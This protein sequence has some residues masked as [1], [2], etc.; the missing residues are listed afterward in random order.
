MRWLRA[1]LFCLLTLTATIVWA[2]DEAEDNKGFIQNLIE[3]AL[4]GLGREVIITDFAGALSSSITM[5]EMTIADDTGVWLT[6]RGVVLDWKR[7]AL[8][9][10]RLDVT[11]LAAEEII[12]SRSPSADPEAPAA[13]ASVFALPELPVAVEID[14]IAAPRIVLGEALFGEE[15]TLALRGSAQ[16]ADGAGDVLL[17]INRVDRPEDAMALS[18]SFANEDRNLNISLNLVEAPSG[19]LSNVLNLPDAPSIE[20]RVAGDGP[21]DNFHADIGLF[22]NEESRLTG[23]VHFETPLPFEGVEELPPTAFDITFTGDVAPLFATDYQTFFGPEVLLSAKG[24]REKSG[25]LHLQS[26]DVDTQALKLD[27]HLTLSPE[28]WPEKFELTGRLAGLAGA[29]VLLPLTGERTQITEAKILL[30]YDSTAG[31]SWLAEVSLNSLDRSDITLASAKLDGTGTLEH[32]EGTAIGQILG[33]VE[34]ALQGLVLENEA[35][36]KAVGSDLVA[37]LTFAWEEDQVFR[38]PAFRA[39]GNSFDIAGSGTIDQLEGSL[40]RHVTLDADLQAPDLSLFADLVEQPLSGAAGLKIQGSGELLG[41]SFDVSL[42]GT[43]ENL[44]TGIEQVDGLLVGNGTM[45]LDARRDTTGTHIDDLVVKTPSAE[46]EGSGTLKTGNSSVNLKARLDDSATKSFGLGGTARLALDGTQQGNIWTIKTNANGPG[47]LNLSADADVTVIRQAVKSAKGTLSLSA[48]DVSPYAK[49]TGQPL[50]GALN[51]TLEG[52]AAL[53]ALAFDVT[54]KL[55]ARDLAI[56]VPQVD[57]LIAGQSTIEAK[58]SMEAGKLPVIEQAEAKT[59]QIT[60]TVSSTG[61]AGTSNDTDFEIALKDLGLLVPGINGPA[62]A[63]GTVGFGN[64]EWTIDANAKAPGD[65][66]ANVSGTAK[67]NGQD[68]DLKAKGSVPLAIANDSIAPQSVTGTATYD[69][70]VK[71]PPELSSVSGQIKTGGAAV[72][73]PAASIT[74][75]NLTT[76]IDLAKGNAQLNAQTNVSSGGQIKVS[77][78]IS[79]TA[80]YN[81]DIGIDLVNVLLVD[82]TLYSTSLNGRVTVKGAAA[83]GAA[84]NGR[85]DLGTTEIRIPD[86]TGADSALLPGMR[87]VNEPS[88]VYRTRVYGGIVEKQKSGGSQ[89]RPYP[90][91]LVINAPSQIFVRGRGLDAEL[92]GQLEL[93]GTTADLIPESEFNLIR[94]R[95]DLL[96]QR[97]DLKEGS[98]SLQGGFVPYVH[99]VSTSDVDSTTVKIEIEG[100]LSEPDVVFS[101]SPELPEDEVLALLLFGTELDKI[102]AF[103]AVQ[104]ANSVAILAGKGGIGIVSSLR[105]SFGLDDFNVTTDDEGNASATAGKYLSEKVYSDVTFESN[106]E[107]EINLNYEV[108]PSF[109]VRGTAKSDGDTGFG[110]FF[111][112]DY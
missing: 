82:P 9:T 72:S 58:A 108:S 46:I 20:L 60:A 33:S 8:L 91:N 35:L 84:I 54:S 95:L 83:G 80:P 96:G 88:A 101:S 67:D 81:A 94:G 36:S 112:R 103:Q 56:G 22:T 85:I 27:G 5:G 14:E 109:K 78:P 38:L 45:S 4:S 100:I 16:I 93:T 24:N 68:L 19:F 102:S 1:S 57:A 2:Q 29:P 65:I 97:L 69:L 42:H 62:S 90:I 7:V 47:A 64:G 26:L 10:G 31:N 48:S 23:Q 92:G 17:N 53:D 111:E 30:D 6:M 110:L 70:V 77:G 63:N 43:T 21:L 55:T 75:E 34:L 51:L 39:S 73:I 59:D 98:I 3:D 11:R 104:L 44:G 106:G 105:E 87:H 61:S 32:G 13:E 71:G 12:L 37:D 66:T 99:L 52:E 41:G 18:G 28:N 76:T 15:T 86:G 107:S 50:T 79:L 40:D 89:S 74:L 49:L 25:R